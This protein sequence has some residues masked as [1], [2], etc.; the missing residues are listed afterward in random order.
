[1]RRAEAFFSAGQYDAAARWFASAAAAKDFAHADLSAM[2]QAAS[3]VEQKK[4]AEAAKLYAAI[5]ERFPAS[6]ERTAALLAAGNCYEQSGDLDA[7][8]RMFR[9]A[10]QGKDQTA[11]EAAHWLARTYLQKNQPGEALAAVDQSLTNAQGTDQAAR[12]LLDRA[13]A[14][15]ALPDRRA[16]SIAAY[17]EVA[18]QHADDD[19]APQA[20]YMAAYASLEQGDYAAAATFADAFLQKHSGDKLATDVRY[21][22]AE[23]DLQRQQYDAAARKYGELLDTHPDHAD[24]A[25]WKVRLALARFLDGKHDAVLATLSPLVGQIQSPEL[26]AEAQYLLGSAQAEL[27]QSDAAIASL[28]ASLTAE[29]R[30]QRRR[31]RPGVGGHL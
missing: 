15:Y 7:A 18:Q 11:L 16:D 21:I 23:A 24:A 12:L 2:R 31:S 20:G 6:A 17:A 28:K 4:L 10:A 1:M 9:Q 29:P 22:A 8:I 13:D 19:Q 26:A 14:L 27:G 30:G 25:R 5:P 3:L